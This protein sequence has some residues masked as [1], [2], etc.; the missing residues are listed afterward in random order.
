VNSNFMVD[1]ETLGTGPDAA[2]LSIG[3]VRFD[4][5]NPDDGSLTQGF[6]QNVS[7]ESALESGAT[8]DASTI[9]WWFKQ[10]NEARSALFEGAVSLYEALE[11]FTDW[12]RSQSGGRTIHIWG[13]GATFDNVLLTRAYERV[14]L[15]RPWSYRSD[16]C[17]RTLAALFPRVPADEVEGSHTK[18]HN[19][20]YDALHQAEH[21]QKILA[22]MGSSEGWR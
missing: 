6:Y 19:A 14:G 1:L 17:Y 7:L 18:R 5:V 4:T 2:I 9:E 10:S 16:R 15:R 20:L 21:A 12:L 13:N 22:I 8:V 11:R 3:A